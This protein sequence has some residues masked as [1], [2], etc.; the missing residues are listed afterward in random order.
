MS[1]RKIIGRQ[2]VRIYSRRINDSLYFIL[3]P[4]S[5]VDRVRETWACDPC[6]IAERKSRAH[7]TVCVES[8]A[9]PTITARHKRFISQRIVVVLRFISKLNVRELQ[10]ER[11]RRRHLF[12]VDL[13][14]SLHLSLFSPLSL[15]FY[16]P[17]FRQSARFV[18]NSIVTR[19]IYIVITVT[20]KIKKNHRFTILRIKFVLNSDQSLQ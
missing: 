16:I 18:M 6:F 12:F 19:F 17:L 20:N 9:I 13:S 2:H 8:F 5:G 7:D 10:S 4:L 14:L 15:Y 3:I 1:N 11:T